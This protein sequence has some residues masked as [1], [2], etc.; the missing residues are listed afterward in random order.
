MRTLKLS[1]I[2][3]CQ[4]PCQCHSSSAD[5]ARRL[6]TPS[7]GLASLVCTRKDFFGWGLRI[8]CEWRHKWSSFGAILAHVTWPRAQPLSQSVS[9]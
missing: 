2:S 5:C 1:K 7:N 4:L 6:F 3:S 9:L 8:F